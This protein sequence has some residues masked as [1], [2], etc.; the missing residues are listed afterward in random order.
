MAVIVEEGVER[1]L[2]REHFHV[3]SD[4]LRSVTIDSLPA[5]G[6]L[7]YDGSKIEDKGLT[8]SA[9]D[10]LIG[11][12]TFKPD[13]DENGSGYAMFDYTSHNGTGGSHSDYIIFD[14]IPQSER[15][16]PGGAA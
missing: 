9:V 1:V 4:R 8:I 15:A 14:V 11:N 12:L 2:E 5:R 16:C 7:C 6:A 10:I 3:R 13:G